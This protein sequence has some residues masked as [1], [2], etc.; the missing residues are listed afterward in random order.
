MQ[1]FIVSIN[2]KGKLTDKIQEALT[3]N[4]HYPLPIKKKKSYFS[5]TFSTFYFSWW[6]MCMEIFFFFFFWGGVGQITGE[7]KGIEGGKARGG[8][9]ILIFFYLG[10]GW[11]NLFQENLCLS[12]TQANNAMREMTTGKM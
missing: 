4:L 12:P 1:A 8:N 5:D 11:F 2:S 7:V 3:V 9:S 6:Y 10:M